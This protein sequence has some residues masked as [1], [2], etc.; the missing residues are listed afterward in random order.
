MQ[1][2]EGRLTVGGSSKQRRCL[3]HCESWAA[4]WKYDLHTWERGRERER[5]IITQKRAVKGGA[6]EI[7]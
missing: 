1:R 3:L 5:D 6:T 7:D 2:Q 4:I